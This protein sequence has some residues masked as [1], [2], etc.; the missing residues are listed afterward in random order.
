[1]KDWPDPAENK[2]SNLLLYVEFWGLIAISVTTIC[3]SYGPRLVDWMSAAFLN[4]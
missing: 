2:G 4:T 1:M 3:A